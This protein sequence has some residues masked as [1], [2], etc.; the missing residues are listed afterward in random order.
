MMNPIWRERG[1]IELGEIADSLDLNVSPRILGERF[2]IVCEMTLLRKDGGD[3]VPPDRANR[4][5]DA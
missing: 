5:K 4:R 2:L 1:A 3:P